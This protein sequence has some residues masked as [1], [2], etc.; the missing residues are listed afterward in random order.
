MNVTIHFFFKKMKIIL[1]KVGTKC[2][3]SSVTLV[4]IYMQINIL[5]KK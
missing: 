3:R 1:I 2:L 5:E 4:M